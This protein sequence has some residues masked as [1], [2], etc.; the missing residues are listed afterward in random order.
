MLFPVTP[1]P[2][3]EGFQSWV[4]AVM[5]V[6]PEWLPSDSPYIFYAYNTAVA[7]VNPAF[8]TVPGP[9]YFQMVY[10]LA[11]H[12]LATW[13]PDPSPFPGSPPKP[14]IVID[15]VGYGF[16]QY[17]RKQNNMLG[18]I[19]G[20]VQSSGDE[21][22]NVS[23]VVPKQAQNLTLGQLALTTSIWGRT[24]LGYAQDYGTNWGIS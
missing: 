15:D 21:G 22:T 11:A 17:L 16:W 5:G 4:Y 6:P 7:I 23:L 3:F 14:Y 9:I 2:T 20:T 19:T 24:Y 1:T 13:T 10:N 12:W 18:F 8:Q